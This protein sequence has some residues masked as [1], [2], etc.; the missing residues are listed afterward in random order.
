M[1]DV[2]FSELILIGIVA[3]VIF[4]PEDLPRVARMA[5]HLLGKFRR[6]VADVKSDI[7]REMELADVKRLHDELKDGARSLQDTLNEQARSL[8]ADFQ[9]SI[10]NL[11]Q[12]LASTLS[13]PPEPVSEAV[14]ETAPTFEPAE[15]VHAVAEETPAPPE[16]DENQLDLFGAPAVPA[17]KA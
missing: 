6:Y 8:E 7:S 14:P 9:N 12:E 2:G 3:L 4:G 11:Q 10:G 17:R 5:G 16:A 1:F 13:L 15:E